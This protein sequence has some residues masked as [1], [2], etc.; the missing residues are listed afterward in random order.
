LFKKFNLNIKKYIANTT[1]LF[2]GQIANGIITFTV[3]ILVARYLGPAD[4]GILN[5]IISFV[6]L[7]APLVDLGLKDI[8]IREIVNDNNNK[9]QYLGSAFVIKLIAAILTF[10]LIILLINNVENEPNTR[11]LI[12][13]LAAAYFFQSFN[14]LSF[15]FYATVKAKFIVYAQI[16][17][18]IVSALVKLLFIFTQANLNN[19]IYLIVGENI[20]E[21]ISLL[22]FY[23]LNKQSIH[24]WKFNKNTVK[25]LLSNSWPLILSGIAVSVYM[26]IDQIMLK[27]LAGAEELGNYVIA[28]KLTELW[29]IFPV[30][31]LNSI[32][33][34]I[35][36]AKNSNSKRFE[37]RVQFLSDTFTLFSIAISIVITFL[38]Q[39]LINILFGSKYQTAGNILMIYVWS[40]FF[41]Y[42]GTLSQ[43]LFLVENIQIIGMYTTT[44]GM[45]INIVLNLLL[46]PQMGGKGAA[47]A[48]LISYALSAVFL[49]YLFLRSRKIFLIQIKSLSLFHYV[50]RYCSPFFLKK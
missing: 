11:Y 41:V 21:I 47:I 40:T 45:I 42:S 43:K 30:L 26:K 28:V 16:L 17:R 44:F 15:Y 18:L 36:L 3:G 22:F 14:V 24:L 10:L 35:V 29:Y 13:V 50:R 7:F 32:Y 25:F 27:H 5:Y 20:L 49:N 23:Q 19:F 4:Y 9:E 8:V 2:V 6:A 34:G 12:W 37:S 1:W 31:I 39:N 38:A 33:P 48:T 46:I